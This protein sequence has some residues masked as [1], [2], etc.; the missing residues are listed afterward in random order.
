[1]DA[2]Q[3]LITQ[4]ES[5][6][7]AQLV[8]NLRC[9]VDQFV[10]AML[11]IESNLPAPGGTANANT[12]YAGPT[13]GGAAAPAFRALVGADLPNPGLASLG[14][15]EAINAIAGQFITGISAAGVPTLGYPILASFT[16]SLGANVALNNV[17]TYFDG[18]VVA[19][20]TT[21]GQIWLAS[22]TVTLQDNTG[23]AT[24]R[25]KLWDGTTVIAS[26]AELGT[27]VNEVLSISLSGIITSPAGNLRIS[28]EDASSTNGLI[29]FNNS[30]NAKDS[31]ITALR[32]A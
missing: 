32:I 5:E 10:A 21:A 30:G 17:A 13:S 25:I 9:S 2:I 27:V 31:T 15:I 7:Y 16:N 14:G 1:M 26:T 18:P 20:G 22:G 24:F 19:Q 23:A 6:R 11:E 28:V 3:T 8:Q 29:L 12:V 4:V